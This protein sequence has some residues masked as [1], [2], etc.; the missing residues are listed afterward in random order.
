MRES[1]G[2]EVGRAGA[3][4]ARGRPRREGRLRWSGGDRGAAALELTLF[5]P[6]LIGI[7]LFVLACGRLVES[8]LRLADAAHSA[9]R[10]ASLQRS[11]QAAERA[12]NAAARAALPTASS[13]TRLQVAVSTSRFVPGGS[14]TATISCQVALADLGPLRLPVGSSTQTRSFTST[15]DRYRSTTSIAD[16][17]VP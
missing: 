2:S 3:A 9:A 6:I 13:C 16:G 17:G 8:Q 5:T 12:A 1:I 7:A 10:A 11:P 4:Q 15:V 14:V